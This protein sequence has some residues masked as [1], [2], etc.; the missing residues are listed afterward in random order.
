M[1]DSTNSITVPP[2]VARGSARALRLTLKQVLAGNPFYL[3][4]AGLLLYGINQL[5]TDPKMVGA[6][7]PMLRFNFL[8][9]LIYEILLVV[10]SIALLRRAI[11]Y[12]AMLLF[13]LTNLFIIVP[14]SLISRAVFLSG[15]L[16]WLMSLGGAA[17]AV[18][19]FWAFKRYAPELN[20]PRRL[21]TFGF[22]LLAANAYAPLFFKKIA[23]DPEQSQKWLTWIWVLVLPVLAGFANF[24]P[25]TVGRGNA[26]GRRKWLPGLVFFAWVVVT[27]CHVGGIGYATSFKWQLALL[28]PA[29]WM[30]AWTMQWR[31]ADFTGQ[32]NPIRDQVFRFGLLLLPLL[33]VD[34]KWIL[35]LV[36]ALNVMVYGLRFALKDR[37]RVA[38]IQFLGAVAILLAGLPMAF[39][40]QL[41]PGLARADWVLLALFG[42]W[43][44]LIFLSRDPRVGAMAATA[45]C[46]FC[47]Y[48]APE[49]F[50]YAVQGALVSLLAHSLRWEDHANR[51]ASA[52][53]NLAGVVWLWLA[54]DAWR[55]PGQPARVVIDAGAVALLF[56]YFLH[57]WLGRAWQPKMVLVY[58]GMV[59]LSEP[60]LICSRALYQ[61][62]SGMVAIA[63]S[64]L[65]FALGSIAAFTKPRW[66]NTDAPR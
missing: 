37:G 34:S 54:L 52:L 65:L 14:F 66:G 59:L 6:E 35:P 23:N 22:I 42:S 64:F 21:L 20:L 7:L 3:A 12:D 29:V 57:A 58:A 15:N 51:G 48:F 26:P 38:L 41:T 47:F 46:G 1:P 63:G 49:F 45:L 44:W 62:S 56:G 53:R 43:F 55:E 61:K 18:A 27:V 16:A 4:S 60:V 10:T 2:P 25:R 5:T 36:A 32:P 11:W 39:I 50:R 28:A 17:L 30:M 33:A 31:L 9:L 40:H 19:K 24:L 8:A 13:G